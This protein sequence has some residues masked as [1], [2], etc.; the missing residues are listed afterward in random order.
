MHLRASDRRQVGRSGDGPGVP[1]LVTFEP[2]QP[3]L[4]IK[5]R[6]KL[7]RRTASLL[8]RFA[9]ESEPVRLRLT[10]A[11][12]ISVVARKAP[13]ACRDDRGAMAPWLLLMVEQYRPHGEWSLVQVVSEATPSLL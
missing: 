12:E 5:C 11:R 8:L 9:G 1:V 10:L 2:R 3:Q 4:G 6:W 13:P 7:D